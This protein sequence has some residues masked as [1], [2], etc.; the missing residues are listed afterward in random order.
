MVMLA[1]LEF[2]DRFTL[3]TKRFRYV[4]LAVWTAGL[5]WGMFDGILTFP[6]MANN[7]IPPNP[8]TRGETAHN[9]LIKLFPKQDEL[10]V[11]AP[12]ALLKNYAVIQP[13]TFLIASETNRTLTEPDLL[14]LV[15]LAFDRVSSTAHTWARKKGV[16]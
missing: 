1:C 16:P 3:L 5:L 15:H 12:C 6:L 9:E 8:G 7:N 13:M 14:P 4:I 11:C 10:Q 2:V